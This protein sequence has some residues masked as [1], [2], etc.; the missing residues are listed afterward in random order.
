MGEH[1]TVEENKMPLFQLSEEF[2]QLFDAG[3]KGSQIGNGLL[4]RGQVRGW[5]FLHLV[6]LLDMVVW[7]PLISTKIY[8]RGLCESREGA[9][10]FSS[11][12]LAIM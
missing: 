12:N 11:P 8:L 10:L 2:L 5:G 9:P 1:G 7:C 3:G 6:F 4:K